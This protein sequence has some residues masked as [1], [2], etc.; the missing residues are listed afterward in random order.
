M[1]IYNVANRSFINGLVCQAAL[2][3][4][5]ME[6]S[7][8]PGVSMSSCRIKYRRNVVMTSASVL[9]YVRANHILPS[10]SNAAINE[11]LGC[12]CLSV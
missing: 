5:M 6:S 11:I 12:T 4:R 8:Q 2:S 1:G 3:K 10:V 9:A 7:C